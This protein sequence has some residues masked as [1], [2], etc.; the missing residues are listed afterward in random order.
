MKWNVRTLDEAG[1]VKKV[2]LVA[3]SIKSSILGI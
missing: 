3:G 2:I 1:K